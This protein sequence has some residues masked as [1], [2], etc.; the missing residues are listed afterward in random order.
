MTAQREAIYDVLCA[1]SGHPTAEELFMLVRERVPGISLAT[2]YNTLEMLVNTGL[3]VK[4][5]GEGPARYDT[6]CTP[7]GHTRCMHCSTVEDVPDAV[8]SALGAD[9]SLP[10]GFIPW[11]V[12]VEVKGICAECARQGAEASTDA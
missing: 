2:V 1:A 3:A 9:L 7:H 5:S 6:M 8:V 12:S 11:S 4:I 10:A